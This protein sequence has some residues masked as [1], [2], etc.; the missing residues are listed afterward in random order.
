ML[1]LSHNLWI[2][3]S[4]YVPQGPCWT[5]V[6][7]GRAFAHVLHGACVGAYRLVLPWIIFH[8]ALTSTHSD[9]QPVVGCS[10]NIFLSG[11]IISSERAW[12]SLACCHLFCSF[13]RCMVLWMVPGLSVALQVT[14][15]QSALNH[16]YSGR[17][18][19]ST[20]VGC[21]PLCTSM[22]DYNLKSSGPGGLVSLW[23]A[24]S[25]GCSP[26]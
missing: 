25:V 17:K 12:T 11:G 2:P 13:I 7:V 4:P 8:W 19:G 9:T 10:C 24:Y 18:F 26:L 21:Y 1:S 3:L 20:L 5:T 16:S 23:S 15:P 14:W 6:A 22:T